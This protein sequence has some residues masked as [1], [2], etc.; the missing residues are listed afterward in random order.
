MAT[1]QE[2]LAESLKELKKLQNHAGVAIVKSSDLTRTHL[3]RLVHNG[4][5]EEVMKG[6]YI[7]SRPDIM[8]GDTTNWFTS[9]WHFVSYYANISFGDDWS[10]SADQSL[11]IYSGNRTAPVQLIIRVDKDSNNSVQLLHNTSILYFKASL[12]SHIN[13]DSDFNLNLYSLEEALIEC[14]PDFFKLDSISARTCLSMVGDV[15]DI[16]K[17]LLEKG[18]TTKAGRL[19][20]A[21]RNIGNKAAADEIVGT[22]KSLGY[23]IREEDPFEQQSMFEYSRVSSPYIARLKLM[24][25]K[26]RPMVID[27]FPA[28]S[29]RHTDIESCL[30]SIDTQ[31]QQDAYHSL[32]I[33]GYQV[34]DE[35]I[36]K[37]E[38]GDWQPD[39]NV[40][41]AELRNTMAARG[42]W[43]AFQSVKLSIEKILAGVNPGE[44]A[45]AEHRVWYRELYAPAVM[46]GLIKP[47]DLAGYRN[48]QV[49]I[50]GS[51]HIPLSADAVR[52]IM[53]LLFE[54]LKEEPDA[55]VR[56]VLGH[57]FLGYIHPYSDGNGRIARFLM[58]SM[59]ISGGYNWVVIPVERRQ[60]YMQV[61]EEASVRENIVPFTQFLASLII[62]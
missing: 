10:L 28:T 53:P 15:G 21:F 59:L 18:Q 35:L 38:R 13:K 20:G 43:Q 56:A 60:E 61:L 22:M 51:K 55:R 27:N 11:A 6:W 5:L 17:I 54:L 9:Y 48:N 14:S 25:S 52:Y 50:R 16:L 30:L 40:E 45:E 2:K 44:V 26:M 47:A 57:F 62:L 49:Y 3:Q 36:R 7:S 19:A 41:D 31:Y 4:F 42:Y 58:N 37:V 12:A 32:S 46:V 34:T 29:H 39:S 33:E 24:W 23:D 8:Q 1:I